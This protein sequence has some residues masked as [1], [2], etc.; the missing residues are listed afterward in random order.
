[1]LLIARVRV[2]LVVQIQVLLVLS[3][4]M[5]TYQVTNAKIHLKN[6]SSNAP[7]VVPDIYIGEPRVMKN[8]QDSISGRVPRVQPSVINQETVILGPG[9]RGLSV[10]V[11]KV[12]KNRDF[13]ATLNVK[14]RV[15]KVNTNTTEFSIGASPRVELASRRVST[16]VGNVRTG[17]K[18]S[19][20][21]A[22]RIANLVR[23]TTVCYAIHHD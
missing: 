23:A 13:C 9:T 22:M 10:R 21:S 11:Q 20:V 18:T 1:V 14:T 2:Q 6:A 12:M 4:F 5:H 8:V 3:L 19:R 7:I 15:I 17:G 16:I